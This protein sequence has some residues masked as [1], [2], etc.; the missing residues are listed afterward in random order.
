MAHRNFTLRECFGMPQNIVM[1][2]PLSAVY[3]IAPY[4]WANPPHVTDFVGTVN[5]GDIE[6]GQEIDSG[7]PANW[8]IPD[9][10]SFIT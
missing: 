5:D 3:G 2:V 9:A 4:E 1:R 7:H 8:K 10:S 6:F